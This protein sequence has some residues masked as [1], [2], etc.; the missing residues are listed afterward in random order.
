MRLFI[1]LCVIALMPTASL[2]AGIQADYP[3]RVSLESKPGV[4]P[5]LVC[6]DPRKLRALCGFVSSKNEDRNPMGRY[7]FRFQTILFKMSCADPERDSHAELI[8]KVKSV[9]GYYDEEYLKCNNLQF[10]VKNGMLSKFAIYA[11]FDQYVFFMAEFGLDLTRID[12][13]DNK[14]VLD[15]IVEQRGRV[16]GEDT[17][18]NLD[19]YYEMLRKAGAKHSYEVRG[20]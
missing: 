15:Y 2:A 11:N 16:V 6:D 8:S 17:K 20:Q 12:K 7:H 1:Y 19:R 3:R 14:T 5:P 10:D 18:K 9:W 4:E 13:A